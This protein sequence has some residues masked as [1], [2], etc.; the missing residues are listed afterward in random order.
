MT[1]KEAKEF[2]KRVRGRKIVWER[3][4]GTLGEVITPKSFKK[5]TRDSKIEFE[6]ISKEGITHWDIMEGFKKTSFGK[7]IFADSPTTDFILED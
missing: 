5:V 1:E 3:S 4:S 6:I 2:L 7:W